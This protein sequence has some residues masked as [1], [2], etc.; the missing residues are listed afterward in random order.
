MPPVSKKF[1]IAEATGMDLPQTECFKQGAEGRIFK[2]EYLGRS[3]L[4]KE[5]FSKKYR[6]PKLDEQLTKERITAEIRGLMKCRIAGIRTPSVY[7]VN[8]TKNQIIMEFIEGKTVKDILLI[9]EKNLTEETASA[10]HEMNVDEDSGDEDEE[11]SSLE[12]P[13][14][15]GKSKTQDT[16]T[17]RPPHPLPTSL[18]EDSVLDETATAATHHLLSDLENQSLTSED[19]NNILKLLSQHM[20]STLSQ[21]HA[22]NII[23]GDLTTSNMIFTPENHLVL[24][25]FGLS[26]IKVSNEDKAV[27]LYVLK[28]AILSLHSVF[29]QRMFD[30]ILASYG[31]EG[32]KQFDT[33]MKTFAEVELRGRKRCMV[34]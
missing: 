14:K 33:V 20:G 22:N 12:T 1:K 32:R 6:H 7:A 21:M 17:P 25:D 5:R 4:V 9:L 34:G 3:V 23:H 30:W 2:T 27:D 10:E 8:S 18:P 15:N 28:R 24:I 13:L 31:R 16:S 19:K 11:I 26:Q 29:S